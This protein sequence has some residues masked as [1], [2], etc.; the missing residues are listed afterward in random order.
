MSDQLPPDQWEPSAHLRWRTHGLDLS[1]EQRW[2]RFV[3]MPET[4]GDIPHAQHA[5]LDR[6]YRVVKQYTGEETWRAV[7]IVAE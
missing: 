7:P 2:V 5:H 3:W 4:I 6:D 1:L